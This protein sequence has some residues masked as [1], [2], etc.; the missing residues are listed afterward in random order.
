[1]ASDSTP[2]GDDFERVDK[3]LSRALERVGQLT[4]FQYDFVMTLIDR[5]DR[6]KAKTLLSDK[7]RAVLDAIDKR[8]A[9]EEA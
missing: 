8:L 1:M 4:P 7:Q 6:Y 9:A 5:V 3:L 2:I